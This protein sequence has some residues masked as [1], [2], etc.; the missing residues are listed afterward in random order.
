MKRLLKQCL[1]AISRLE[2]PLLEKVTRIEFAS[3]GS[4]KWG[5]VLLIASLAFS[6]GCAGTQVSD[7]ERRRSD[8]YYEAASIAWFES[9]DA[10]QAIRNLSRAIEANQ[11][12]DHAHYLLGIIRFMRG[13]T[14]EAEI[15]FQKTIELRK[16]SDRA[17]LAGVQNNLGLLYIH[18]KKYDLAIPLLKDSA[19]EVLNRE[20]WLALGNLGW[21]YTELGEYDKAVASLRR[22]V[23]EQPKFCVGLY[24]LGH[25]Y[26]N[27]KNYE[28]AK[29][30]LL[31]AIRIEEPGCDSIQEAHHLLGMLYLRGQNDAEAKAAFTRCQT[32][33][34][35]TPVGVACAETLE[36]L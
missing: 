22:A 1:P 6:L 13:E 21:A 27:M 24:R 30:S 23:F 34:A 31:A 33:N 2:R 16:G 26:Y 28:A 15:H 32:L 29:E 18:A 36:G 8:R 5:A 35:K 10:L 4:L 17:G 14:E 3:H 12:N 25:A 7:A 11:N 19:D 20:P 9:Q